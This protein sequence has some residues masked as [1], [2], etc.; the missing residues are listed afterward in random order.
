MKKYILVTE[1]GSDMSQHYIDRHNIY[2]VP[3]HI[4]MGSETFDDGDIKAKDIFSYYDEKGELPS[5][6]GSNPQDF[7]NIFDKINKEH[8]N[9]EIIYIAY[10]AVTTV[11]Y[12]S[13]RIAAEDY[14]NVHLVDSKNCTLGLATIVIAAAEFIENNPNTTPEEI[15]KFVE[16][17]REK[18]RFSFLPQ[19][20][21]YLKAGGR[22]S[23]A[24]YLGARLLKIFPSIDLID[25]YLVAGKKYRGS[26]KMA[27]KVLLKDYFEKFNIDLDSVRLVKVD[28]LSKEQQDEITKIVE[29]NT[30]S[31][32][33]WFDAGAVI[34]CHGG[35][36]AF[37]IVG[38]EK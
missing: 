23:N 14:P 24:S 8:P 3:M 26:F 9:C 5:T 16:E 38:F 37:G 2:I 11:S 35:P 13:A 27:Y 33:E 19:T 1:S 15:I 30:N 34:A 12:N 7:V 6:A 4:N 22:I 28:G 31:K 10:S 21:L 18:T 29:E 32:V 36:G 25:G 20:L 17:L